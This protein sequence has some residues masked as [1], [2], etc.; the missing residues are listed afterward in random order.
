MIDA[1]FYH[2]GNILNNLWEIP[3]FQKQY[4]FSNHPM[5]M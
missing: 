5:K 1:A 2:S 4:V 3:L